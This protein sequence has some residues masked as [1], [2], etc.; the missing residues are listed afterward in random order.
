MKNAV[1]IINEF[2]NNNKFNEIHQWLVD[3]GKRYDI[4]LMIYTNAQ[5][6]VSLGQ[7]NDNKNP[8]LEKIKP[9]F[10][11]F[12]DKDIRLAA[13][14]EITGY[15][16]FN[17]SNGI[18]VCDDKSLTHMLL[19]NAGIPMP[20]TII[21]PMTYDGIGY[22]NYDFITQVTDNLGFPMILKECFGS[23]GKQVYFIKNKEELI[24]KMKEIG[25]KPMLFQEFIKSSFARDIRLNVVGDKVVA[26]MY[27]YSDTGD[28]RANI[29]NGGKMKKYTP[30][31]EQEEIAVRCCKILGLDFAG[32]DIMFGEREEPIIC[33]VNSNAHFKNIYDCTGVNVADFMMEYIID[34]L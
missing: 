24:G 1:L 22:T 30:T 2:L 14:L 32:V 27:R 33:E 31:K 34:N 7:S 19:Q 28:F 17:S 15:R 29:T 9:E 16:V 13:H 21:A 23:F 12:W 4:N 11:L 18:N 3:A 25:T 6:M 26:S 10:V 8:I 20:K 5:I